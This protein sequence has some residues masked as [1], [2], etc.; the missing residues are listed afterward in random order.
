[1][2]KV[3]VTA[4]PIAP[5]EVPG[6]AGAPQGAPGGLLLM[7]T[8]VTELRQA[9]A[10]LREK[11]SVIRS[12]YRSSAMA[13]GIVELTEDDTR[14]VS[15]NALTERFFG[16]EPGQVE[17]KSAREI[18]VP[19]DRL[20]LWLE[21]FRECRDTG[22]PV[23]F[24][25]QSVYPSLWP[26]SPPWV[27]A[28]LSLLGPS[29]PGRTLCSFIVED[30]TER[31]RGEV[32]LCEAK[33][34]AEAAN[35]AK[36][37]FLAVLSH[38]L[39]T[40]LTPVLIAISML[41]EENLD[42]S[43]LPTLEMIR[44]NIELESRLIDDL[45]DL[46]RITRGSLRLDLEVVDIHEVIGRSLEICRDETLV[47]GLNVVS[48]LDAPHHNVLADYAR[49]MQIVWNL[50]HNAARYSLPGGRL[51][52]RTSNAPGPPAGGGLSR[53]VV[54]FEDTGIGIDAE[55]LVRIFEP[56]EQG[57][58][59]PRGHRGGLGL[60]LAICRSLAE[61]IGGRL[62]ASSPGRGRGSTF[63]LELATTPAPTVM[64][65]PGPGGPAEAPSGPAPVRH[66]LHILL[67]ED[68]HDTLRYLSALLRRHGHEV[69]TADRLA[70]ARTE[71][72]SPE[73]PFD[74]LLSDIELPDGNGL[75]LMREARELGGIAGIAMSGFGAE[76]DL[77][78]SRDAGFS[79][80]M[81]KPIDLDELEPAMQRAV[82]SREC[83]SG[84][85]PP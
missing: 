9:E 6:A 24:E 69:V 31:K 27:A 75:D 82:V 62:T 28:T 15:A 3:L 12:F 63:V 70:S 74:L 26:T 19:P 40:P 11:E 13:M 1:V 85:R 44:R 17:G 52:I 68:N 41:L 72:R 71:L 35:L 39:R 76:D 20:E 57:L 79:E 43:L 78:M 2:R 54:E 21:R 14:F 73:R 16:L 42:P 38:E 66:R 55:S 32:A 34:A 29:G 33:E 47:S 37:R 48:A 36:D 45:L 53:L 18:G 81:T 51:T 22:R 7:V 84:N 80:H 8:D 56:F 10:A 83:A 23:R 5:D 4:R 77:R 50:I 65:E 59:D 30:V 49:L 46:S 60:G 64:P 58:N 67:V 25:Y 61:A